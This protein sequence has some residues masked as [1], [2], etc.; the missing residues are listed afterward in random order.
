[1][2]KEKA[3]LLNLVVMDVGVVVLVVD[4]FGQQLH[5]FDLQLD[6]H[7]KVASGAQ[8]QRLQL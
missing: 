2:E 5:C 7:P 6:L 4:G 8:V 1:M 3:M